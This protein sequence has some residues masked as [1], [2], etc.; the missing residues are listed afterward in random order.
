MDIAYDHIQEEALSPFSPD[1]KATTT[2]AE[3]VEP[4]TNSD[5]TATNID[6][7]LR[8]AVKSF[9]SS[10][11]GSTLGGWFNTARK[12]GED[13]YIGLQQE[14][15]EAQEEAKK[16][17][18][19]LRE[20]VVN[21]TRSLSLEFAGEGD[22]SGATPAASAQDPEQ[23]V[24]APDN[25]SNAAAAAEAEAYQGDTSLDGLSSSDIVR[26]AGTLVASLRLTAASKLKDLQRAEDAADEA[27]LKFGANVRNFLKDAVTISAPDDATLGAEREVLFETQEAGTG[28]KVVHASR[29]EALLHAIHTNLSS[30]TQDPTGDHWNTWTN[31]FNI[32]SKT[33]DIASDLKKHADLRR[34][35][36]KLVPE[37]VDYRTFWMRYYFLRQAVEDDERRRKEVLKGRIRFHS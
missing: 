21:R 6:T 7:E 8:T 30:F 31:T 13:F 10:Q 14:A 32:D 18:M 19:S 4:P 20:Q 36:E 23:R 28:K 34:A 15:A 24:A 11:W 22:D 2:V 3:S 35:M 29:L 9:Q 5:T 1:R 26:E 12:Q 25:A 16:S 27:L 33:A 17:L 37:S